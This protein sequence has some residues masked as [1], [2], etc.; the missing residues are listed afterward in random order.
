MH[1][2]HISF[3]LFLILLSLPVSVYS[4][5]LAEILSQHAHATGFSNRMKIKTLTSI[6]TITQMG[7]ALPISIIQKRPNKYRFDVHLDDGRITQ[8][9]DGVIG[10]SYN[11][12][13]SLDTIQL[14]G[15]E[16][17]Q[18][19]ESADFDGILHTYRTKGYTISLMGKV[20][21]G[22]HSAYKIQIKKQS[23]EV[24]YF[25][26]DSLSYLVIKTE[27]NL[28]VNKMPYV[29]ESTFGDYR[30]AGGITVPFFIQSKNGTLITELRISTIRI[31]EPMEDYYFSCRRLTN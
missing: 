1:K 6:G 23:G 18:I 27:A 3:I 16:L 21:V 24:L 8:A 4:Q 30:K 9:Y 31:N 19:R 10:W 15:A 7:A 12:Y 26:I 17:A 29:A 28:L 22:L 14:T 20:A 5:T 11:P 25:F 2:K 13:S